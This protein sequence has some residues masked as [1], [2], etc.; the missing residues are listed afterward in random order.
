M[1]NK[2]V[3]RE[4]A[5][6]MINE[7][8]SKN[9]ILQLAKSYSKEHHLKFL[10]YDG[11]NILQSFNYLYDENWENEDAYPYEVLTYLF[12]I[13]FYHKDLIW[14]HCS[15]GRQLIDCIMYGN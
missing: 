3:G 10:P 6:Y 12:D 8:D 14:Q 4:V 11:D 15:V 5:L 7:N 13:M 2:K 1:H 9:K